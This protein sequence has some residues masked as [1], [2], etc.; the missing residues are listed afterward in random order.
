MLKGT[1]SILTEKILNDICPDH[2]SKN[3]VRNHWKSIIKAIL[4]HITTHATVTGNTPNGGP[5]VGGK[6]Q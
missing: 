6:V 3:A 1:D 2:E 4:E 5:V